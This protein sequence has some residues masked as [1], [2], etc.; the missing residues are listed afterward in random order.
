MIHCSAARWLACRL[1]LA[2]VPLIAA[3][4]AATYQGTVDPKLFL[5][6][7]TFGGGAV[8]P[9]MALLADPTPMQFAVGRLKLAEPEFV[10][11]VGTIVEAAATAAFADVLGRPL[12]RL[13][14]GETAM[15]ASQSLPWLLAVRPVKFELHD[16]FLP[17]PLPTTFLFLVPVPTRQDVRV[18]VDC[19]VLDSRRTLLWSKRFDSGDVKL[20]IGRTDDRD[21]QKA[22]YFVH[23]THEAAYT[24]MHR[25][26]IELRSW[27]ETERRREQGN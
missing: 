16:E 10:I 3:G 15:D 26:A 2:V 5:R 24:I 7:P 1:L 21:V 8:A 19:E 14:A 25:A 23:M 22:H 9:R 20:P 11:P 13:P 17:L 12:E 6:E 18:V 4:C 27:S